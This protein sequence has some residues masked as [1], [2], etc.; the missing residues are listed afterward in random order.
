MRYAVYL[1][2]LLPIV[3]A[4]AA[5]PLAERLP[6]RP[7][8]WLLTVSAVVLAAASSAALGLLMLTGLARIPFLAELAHLSVAVVAGGDLPALPVAAAAGVLLAIAGGAAVRMAWRRVRTLVMAAQQAACLPGN[9]QLVVLDDPSP[10]AFALPGLPGRIVVSTGMLA[11][12]DTAE[13]EVLLAHERTHLRSHHYLFTAAVQLAAAANPLLRPAATAVGY[14]VERW[15]DEN[16]V[17][18]CGDR[19][20]VATTVGKA[21]LANASAEQTGSAAAIWRPGVL[22]IVGAWS[23]RRS[24]DPLRSAGPLPRRVAA[25]LTAPATTPALPVCLTLAL[26]MVTGL[27]CLESA[28]DL[29]TLLALAHHSR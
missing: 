8:T 7:A 22:A 9:D 3:A 19:R 10:E 2:L 17:T 21:A 29:H 16:A 20:L 25:L 11:T 14:T 15:A 24:D 4:V 27:S 6:P 26:L 23:R 28:N 18:A 5:R 12:L 1:P 13:Q